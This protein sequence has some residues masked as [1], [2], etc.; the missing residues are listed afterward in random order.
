MEIIDCNN[1]VKSA[2][3]YFGPSCAVNSLKDKYNPIGDNSDRLCSLCIGKIPGGRCTDADPYAGYDGAFR[4]LLEAGEVAFLKHNTV[5]EL[6]NGP[7]FAGKKNKETNNNRQKKFLILGTISKDTFELICKDGSRRPID[8]FRACNWGSVP[9]NAIVTSSATNVE[10]RLKLQKFLAKAAQ[11]YSPNNNTFSNNQNRN[12][13]GYENVNRNTFGP[14]QKVEYDA[15]GNRRFKRQSFDPV[16]ANQNSYSPQ[17]FDTNRLNDSYPI[18]NQNVGGPY[19][20]FNL[21]ESSP[22]YGFRLNLL[23]QVFIYLFVIVLKITIFLFLLLL[24][25]NP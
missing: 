1:H 11:L 8:D 10:D 21:F 12:P 24:G 4:C 25:C 6:V 22:K 18:Q 17:P 9:T 15:F 2:I 14:Q 7:E 13:L 3:N 19:E 5:E 16:F 23:F 20:V